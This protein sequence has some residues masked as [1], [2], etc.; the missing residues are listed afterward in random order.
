M[1]ELN[2]FIKLHRKLLDWEWFSDPNT[3]SVFVFCL[4]SANYDGGNWK[5]VEYERGQ[6]I[7]S[8]PSISEKTGLSV[9][10][11]RTALKHLKS[12]GEI[13]DKTYSKFRLITL[14]NYEKYQSLT[15]KLTGNQQSTNSQLTGNQQQIKNIKNYKNIKKGENNAR[16]REENPLP[17][18]N[19]HGRFE[20]VLLTDAEYQSLVADYGEAKTKAYIAC[21]DER[22]EQHGYHWNN[23]ELAIRRCHKENWVKSNEPENSEGCSYDMDE[24]IRQSDAL[25]VYKKRGRQ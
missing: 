5:G 7:T 20:H 8:I 10:A 16:T 21:V 9:Q 19:A 4:I 1:A 15:V 18:K 3:L 11:V 2:G 17:P 25:P 13:T 23:H 24:F 22:I 14:N 12:T 6:F